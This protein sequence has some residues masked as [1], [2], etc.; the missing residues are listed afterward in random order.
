[1]TRNSLYR[2]V[3]ASALFLSVTALPGCGGGGGSS[4][5]STS[6][7]TGG[8]QTQ[9]FGALTANVVGALQTPVVGAS[10]NTVV[11][12]VA[13]ASITTLQAAQSPNL[14]YTQIAFD[15]NGEVYTISPN[16]ANAAELTSD[17]ITYSNATT[18]VWLLNN[19]KIAFSRYD[20]TVSHFQIFTIN[21]DKTGMVRLTDGTS[22]CFNPSAS[23]TNSAI[24]YDTY[25]SSAGAQQIYSI[26][27]TGGAATRLS[28]GVSVDNDPTWS[29]DGSKYAYVHYDSTAGHYQIY[30]ANANGSGAHAVFSAYATY[31]F[32]EPAWSPDGTKIAF[33]WKNGSNYHIYAG[34]VSG[35]SLQGLTSSSYDDFYPAW[36]PDGSKITF[37]RTDSTGH[38]QIYVANADGTQPARISDGSANDATPSWS[39][40]ITKRYFVGPAGY[41]YGTAA[42]GFLYSQQGTAI[43][44]LLTFDATTPSGT[45]VAAL[46]T[47]VANAPNL[48]FTISASDA[49]TG[50][51]YWNGLTSTYVRVIGA[52]STLATATNAIVS[53]D[54]ATGLVAS[55][56]PYATSHVVKAQSTDALQS[57]ISGGAIVLQGKFL[58]AMDGKGNNKAPQGASEV[59]IDSHTGEILSVQ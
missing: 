14:S 58:A 26:N 47:D 16:G 24:L 43:T 50:L 28:T 57:H 25:N 13:G 53:F 12:G 11:T 18:P 38:S 8:E 31:D 41:N 54:A 55:V 35:A 42:S 9:T 34:L 29:P 37:S 3:S 20:T 32:F 46:P 49:L 21:A 7:P 6:T 27:P 15:R 1:M 36:A 19:S 59:R 48:I 10:A 4:S 30:I 5:S 44:S 33:V 39:T 56:L 51:K 17:L 52:G 23:P 45:R 2:A 40:L 22:D